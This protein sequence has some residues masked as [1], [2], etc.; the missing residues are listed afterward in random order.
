[1]LYRHSRIITRVRRSKRFS[2]TCRDNA[3]WDGDHSDPAYGS[4]CCHK[5]PQSCYGI[6]V[7]ISK[8]CHRN[9]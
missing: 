8:C 3:D 1:M 9:N 2:E 7:I 4:Q 6:G 5:F